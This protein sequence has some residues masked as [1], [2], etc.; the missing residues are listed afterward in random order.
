MVS[1]EGTSRLEFWQVYFLTT[2]HRW[3]TLILV[4]TDSDRRQGRNF[5][6]LG[7]AVLA[8]IVVLGTY[9]WTDAFLCLAMVDY[10]WNSWHFASQ[11]GGVL[12][13]YS[14]K[15]GGGRPWL[16]TICVRI[17][18][19]YV[20][21]RLAGWTTGWAESI[22]LMVV[23][24]RWMDGLVLLLP[25]ILLLTEMVSR[26]TGRG[27]AKTVYLI[28]VMSL[29]VSLLLS[30]RSGYHRLVITLTV[31]SAAF[32]AIE[33]LA[34]VT[35]YAGRRREFGSRALFQMMAKRWLELL[36]IFVIGFGAFASYVDHFHLQI[37]LG[38]NFWAAF[39]HYAYD[40]L[41]WKLRQP[42]TA[43]TLDVELPASST[44]TREVS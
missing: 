20:C 43:N 32:H 24:I 5:L 26:Q 3:L 12:R 44:A 27:L 1:A 7:L 30:L 11:H 16:E 13:I 10:V 2:P 28:S 39:L 41:I 40:G 35:Y 4:V 23:T 19:T 18:V 33:Y 38:L 34:V 8:A 21:L 15:H 31:A 25:M 17:F 22:P 6:F 29:Y 37:W 36:A 42:V 14:R 9:W